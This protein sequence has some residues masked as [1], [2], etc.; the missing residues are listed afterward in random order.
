MERSDNQL[1]VT[2]IGILTPFGIGLEPLWRA[3]EQ[4]RHSQTSWDY[5][6]GLERVKRPTNV[7]HLSERLGIDHLSKSG[8]CVSVCTQQAIEQSGLARGQWDRSRVGISIGSAFASAN[9]VKQFSGRILDE[10]PEA[11]EPVEFPNT[12]SNAAAGYLGAM[13]GVTGL[14]ITF[15]AGLVSSSIAISYACDAIEQNMIDIAI[16]GGVEEFVEGRTDVVGMESCSLIVIERLSAAIRRGA[17]RLGYLTTTMTP[18]IFVDSDSLGK[19]EDVRHCSVVGQNGEKTTRNLAA[20]TAQFHGVSTIIA[21]ALGIFSHQHLKIRSAS[22]KD[23]LP[24]DFWHLCF[25]INP[26]G[27]GL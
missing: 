11:I 15:S 21:Y 24:K 12:V 26:D 23:V 2:G 20:F 6:P 14:N 13:F 19:S 25:E 7:A 22:W 8:L 9:A 17:P 16:A 27:H 1:C 3:Y 10:G 5:S 4:R 18:P